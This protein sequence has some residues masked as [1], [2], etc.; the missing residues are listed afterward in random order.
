ML[1]KYNG[2]WITCDVT[3]K[4]ILQ[5]QNELNPTLNNN[6]NTLTSRNNL[7]DCF[8]NEEHIRSFFGE[9][10]F[11]NIEIHKF[12]KIKD[13]LKSFEMLNM[14]RDECDELLENAIVAILKI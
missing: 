4:K 11:K 6:L 8:E 7:N 5:K 13:K 2:V 14:N 9:I 1:K 10:G 3:P 12:I